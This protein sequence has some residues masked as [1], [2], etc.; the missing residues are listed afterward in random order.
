M[1]CLGA[2]ATKTLIARCR[3]LLSVCLFFSE[4]LWSLVSAKKVLKTSSKEAIFTANKLVFALQLSL[5]EEKHLRCEIANN[6]WF[7]D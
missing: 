3:P 4:T 1:Y 5:K 2:A 6:D 7:P